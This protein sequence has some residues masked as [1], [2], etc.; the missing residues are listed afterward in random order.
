MYIV[1]SV[2]PTD[3][4]CCNTANCSSAS[5]HRIKELTI[6]LMPNYDHRTVSLNYAI[7]LSIFVAIYLFICPF[8]CLVE[9]YSEK[10]LKPL[11]HGKY[12]LC[13]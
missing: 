6:E 11:I 2:H 7:T 9:P 5:F 4:D 12:T 8:L 13:C 1:V 10:N 3:K